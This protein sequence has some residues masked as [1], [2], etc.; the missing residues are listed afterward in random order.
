[1]KPLHI[2]LRQYRVLPILLTIFLS[3]LAWVLVG[4]MIATPFASLS[5]WHIAPI[6]AALPALIAGLFKLVE[7]VNKR[8]EVDDH[9]KEDR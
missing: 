7:T 9:D 4:W 1:M 8:F 2:L 3:Y 5:T 6:T